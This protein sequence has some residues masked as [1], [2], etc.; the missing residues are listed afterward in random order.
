[1]VGRSTHADSIA[2]IARTDF[3]P[4]TIRATA[5]RRETR[6]TKCFRPRG[7]FNKTKDLFGISNLLRY[8]ELLGFISRRAEGSQG[9]Y[10]Q[11][12]L[13][14]FALS[15]LSRVREFGW[16]SVCDRE[17]TD[18]AGDSSKQNSE[19]LSVRVLRSFDFALACW[20]SDPLRVGSSENSD[21]GI[22][23]QRM[24]P[25]KSS[26][27]HSE[28]LSVRAVMNCSVGGPVASESQIL[29]HSN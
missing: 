15:P 20:T 5:R 26:K 8:V 17:P 12:C 2:E 23:A 7:T 9:L 25:G 18:K 1:L 27:K 10:C 28:S 19:S 3:H 24:K 16:V 11:H 4:A 29:G 22:A 21:S 14:G 13:P 6:N